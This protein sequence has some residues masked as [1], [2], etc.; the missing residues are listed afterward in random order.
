M[1]K[2]TLIVLLPPEQAQ[3]LQGTQ[4]FPAHRAYRLGKGGRLFR[5]NALNAR[6]GLLAVDS[7]GFE[8]PAEPGPFCQEILRECGARGFRGVVCLFGGERNPQLARLI[9]ELGERLSRQK[10]TV[11]VP[12][13]YGGCSNYARVLVSSAVSGGSL[14]QRLRD[15]LA[16]Y[17]PERVVLFLEKRAE[18]FPLPSPTGSGTQLTPEALGEL[19]GRLEPSVFFSQELCARYFT[20]MS[21]ESGGHF[22]LFD[23][24]ETLVKKMEVSQKLGVRWAM[25]MWEDLG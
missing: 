10:L 2:Q 4:M 23:D 8:G 7:Q 12:E 9:Q 6:G 5:S 1:A 13:S 21:R 20:Y 24:G 25:G 19:M 18:D 15:V 14:E 11:Y 16:Q 3:A 22:V 17:G